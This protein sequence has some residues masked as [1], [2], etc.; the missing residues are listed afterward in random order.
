MIKKLT[1]GKQ[2]LIGSSMG[3]WV[4]L[5]LCKL[6]PQ[7]VSAMIGLAPAPDFPQK[8]IWNNMN[9]FQRRQLVLNKNITFLKKVQE[10]ENL[11]D[12]W[13]RWIGKLITEEL[14]DFPF[15]N[16][17]FNFINESPELFEIRNIASF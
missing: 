13:V 1:T 16:E 5:M 12:S 4:M 11:N 2:I 6:L 3:G 15:F 10:Q 14:I 8:L 9:T 17:E 7:K